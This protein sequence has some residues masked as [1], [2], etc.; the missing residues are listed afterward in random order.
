VLEEVPAD[1]RNGAIIG[2]PD[3]QSLT[4]RG[5]AKVFNVW[6]QRELGQHGIHAHRLR[7]SFAC[8]MLWNRADLK[9]IQELLGHANL[10]TTEWYIKAKQEDKIQAVASIPDFG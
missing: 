7:H 9:T 8:L 2:R 3:G 4:T 6:L 10:G 1:Q 5:L